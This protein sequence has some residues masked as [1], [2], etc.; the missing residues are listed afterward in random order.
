MEFELS[1]EQV[2]L[3]DTVR[4]VLTKK[5]DVE[6]LRAVTDTEL[7]WS[8]EVWNSLA[9]IGILGLVFDETDGGTGAGPE[10]LAPVMGE[11]GAAI[12]PEPFLDAVVVPGLLVSKTADADVRADVIGGL[13]SGERLLAL[14]PP[15]ERR[16]LARLR[17]GDAVRRRQAVRHQVTGLRGRHRRHP[18]GLGARRRG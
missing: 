4:E 9:E 15:R 10:E 6:T 13:S 1:E 3:R 7:G 17:R 2:M 8:R 14:R 12:A 11:F 5:Y 16:P 18:R